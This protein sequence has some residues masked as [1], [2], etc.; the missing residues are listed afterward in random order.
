[1]K[2]STSAAELLQLALRKQYCLHQ[3]K[4]RGAAAAG[5][6]VQ[7]SPQSHRHRDEQEQVYGHAK[8]M[9]ECVIDHLRRSHVTVQRLLCVPRPTNLHGQQLGCR[10]YEAQKMRMGGIRKH[11]RSRSPRIGQEI[12]LVAV[13]GD[14]LGSTVL[15]A[16]CYAFKTRTENKTSTRK[17]PNLPNAD[18]RSMFGT[19]YAEVYG[20]NAKKWWTGH[21]VRRTT[22]G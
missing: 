6:G 13:R 18:M 20:W 4:P 16:L 14:L 10:D 15:H 19:R 9:G 21:V 17:S 11:K 2:A 3:L 5:R 12:L 7:H 8:R 22:T 1:M